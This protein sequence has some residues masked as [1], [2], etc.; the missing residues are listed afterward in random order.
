MTDPLLEAM[1]LMIN[2]MESK[3]KKKQRHPE[4]DDNMDDPPGGLMAEKTRKE[5]ERLAIDN[6]IKKRKLVEKER[7]IRMLNDVSHTFQ[8][9]VVDT[10]RR[11]APIMAAMAKNPGIERDFEIFLSNRNRDMIRSVKAIINQNV[12]DDKYG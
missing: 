10:P 6:E 9:A 11:D 3:P 1:D 8:T 7:V 12:Q 4:P 5:I 2:Q